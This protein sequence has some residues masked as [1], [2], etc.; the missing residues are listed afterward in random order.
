MKLFFSLFVAFAAGLL[1]L[2]RPIIAQDPSET[3]NIAVEHPDKV[4]ELQKRVEEL[5]KASTKPLLLVEQ[6]KAMQ[7]GLQGEPALPNED[8]YYQEETP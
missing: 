2:E 6:F 5:A 1:V 7:K 8:A 4:A 3:K